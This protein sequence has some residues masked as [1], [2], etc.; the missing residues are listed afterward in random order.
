M[1]I[2]PHIAIIYFSFHLKVTA[3]ALS[4]H[5]IGNSDGSHGET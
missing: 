4:V 5:I 1:E 3:H 2:E